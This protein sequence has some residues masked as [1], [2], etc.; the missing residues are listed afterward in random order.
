MTRYN[1]LS[2]AAQQQVGSSRSYRKQSM[3]QPTTKNY[4]M[5]GLVKAEYNDGL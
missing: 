1:I 2:G 5:S 4:V 3:M